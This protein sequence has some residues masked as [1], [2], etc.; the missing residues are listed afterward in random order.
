MCVVAIDLPVETSKTHRKLFFLL[1][2]STLTLMESGLYNQALQRSTG[3]A[4]NDPCLW[5]FDFTQGKKVRF[6]LDT[7]IQ[8]KLEGQNTW[9]ALT[10][11]SLTPHGCG[12]EGKGQ[13]F[14]FQ[15]SIKPTMFCWREITYIDH[16]RNF[17]G[18]YIE[19]NKFKLLF[20]TVFEDSGGMRMNYQLIYC[21]MLMWCSLARELE[22]LHV[23]F[24]KEPVSDAMAASAAASDLFVNGFPKWTEELKAAFLEIAQS[25]L[26]ALKY[27]ANS[28]AAS[29][30]L[31][32][33]LEA[34]ELGPIH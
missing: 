13:E 1:L 20:D 26:L 9:R 19:T 2:T 34:G 30:L 24:A 6:A 14:M 17:T 23:A 3:V 15:S 16:H 28:K 11:M 27:E 7:G 29:P 25:D 32:N 12:I 33:L 4:P 18:T 21:Y 31:T 10:H 22:G 8:C 5:N